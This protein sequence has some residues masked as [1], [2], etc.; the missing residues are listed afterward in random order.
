MNTI[1]YKEPETV[2]EAEQENEGAYSSQMPA[3]TNSWMTQTD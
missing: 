3:T 2:L 1:H